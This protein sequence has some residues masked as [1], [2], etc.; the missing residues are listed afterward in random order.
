M[1]RFSSLA[2]GGGIGKART[3]G[4]LPK[5]CEV[6]HET[7]PPLAPNCLLGAVFFLLLSHIFYSTIIYIHQDYLLLLFFNERKRAI[8]DK[9]IEITINEYFNHIVDILTPMTRNIIA[10]GINV[11]EL[12]CLLLLFIHHYFYFI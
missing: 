1:Q 11:V 8:A 5:S 9:I 3:G 4:E 10:I 2:S 7:T 6:S 12:F